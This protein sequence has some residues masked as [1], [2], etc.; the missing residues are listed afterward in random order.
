MNC[1]IGVSVLFLG[2][3]LLFFGEPSVPPPGVGADAAICAGEARLKI[4]EVAGPDPDPG[5]ALLTGG[6]PGRGGCD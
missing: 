5:A 6:W 3:A 4:P 1:C 2:L